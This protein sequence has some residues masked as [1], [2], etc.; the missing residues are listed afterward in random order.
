MANVE[1]LAGISISIEERDREYVLVEVCASSFRF[2]GSTRAY[3]APAQLS[4]LATELSGFPVDL[5]DTRT[6]DL[7]GGGHIAVQFTSGPT[8]VGTVEVNIQDDPQYS[9]PAQATFSFQV[10]PAAM[11]EFVGALQKL[12]RDL[13]G[14]ARLKGCER[15]ISP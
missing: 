13:E 1:L 4:R 15:F 11:D 9:A 6:F 2:A 14:S 8:G 5:R 12:G 7:N 3:L 10:L